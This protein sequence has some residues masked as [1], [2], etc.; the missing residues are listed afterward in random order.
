M[1]NHISSWKKATRDDPDYKKQLRQ[2][3]QAVQAV[4]RIPDLEYDPHIPRIHRRP[5][6][7]QAVAGPLGTV[8]H[9]VRA[10]MHVLAHAR[11]H[12]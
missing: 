11:M 2:A 8:A 6:G 1:A 3:V 4:A 9:Q 10:F 12:A 7:Y 5:P